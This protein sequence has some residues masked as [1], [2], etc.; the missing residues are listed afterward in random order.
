MS[1]CIFYVYPCGR[2]EAHA[3]ARRPI[4]S[5][6]TV[7]PKAGKPFAKFLANPLYPLDIMPIAM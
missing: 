2:M 1:L 7:Q 5:A 3:P 6:R 4:G